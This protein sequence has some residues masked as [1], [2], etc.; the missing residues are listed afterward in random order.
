MS[1]QED[2]IDWQAVEYINAWLDEETADNYKNQPLAQDW[3]RISKVQGVGED[4]Q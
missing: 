3:A 4:S 2:T 1:Y